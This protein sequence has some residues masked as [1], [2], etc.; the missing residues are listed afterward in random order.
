MTKKMEEEREREK[1]E[2][3]GGNKLRTKIG[4]NL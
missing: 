3:R 1:R 4:P 2:G